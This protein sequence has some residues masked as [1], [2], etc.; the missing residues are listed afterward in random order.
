MS[1]LLSLILVSI[2]ISLDGLG[3][4]I[5]YGLRKMRI[6]FASL[7]V[8]AFCSFS[9]VYTVM[10]FGGTLTQWLSPEMSKLIGAAVLI[11]I[12][13]LTLWKIWR[14]KE[15]EEKEPEIQEGPIRQIRMFGLIIQILRD[16]ERADADRSGDI[17]GW[18][19]VMLGMAL[20]LDAFG[21]GISLSLLGYHPLIVA[22]CVAF[23]SAAILAI[24]I[25]A[26]RRVQGLGWAMRLT[27][28]PP[29]L[30]ISIGLMKC[31]M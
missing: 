25:A 11:I 27:W 26:G 22:F 9:V 23:S 8:I 10:L 24:G 29:L 20:S 7:L 12:G 13:L 18:E 14:G 16:P 5:T 6:P 1:G 2:A 17:R 15:E 28:L 19:A 3:V 4:G 21:A 31:M 30:L